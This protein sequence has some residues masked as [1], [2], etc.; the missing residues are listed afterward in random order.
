MNEDKSG[1]SHDALDD[2]PAEDYDYTDEDYDYTGP[3]RLSERDED[4]MV[5]RAES[6][7]CD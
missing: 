6:G 3:A 4:R 2:G 5:R 1:A 7:H